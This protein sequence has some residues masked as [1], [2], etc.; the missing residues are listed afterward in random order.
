[1]SNDDDEWLCQHAGHLV[2]QSDGR[3]HV[4]WTSAARAARLYLQA[5]GGSTREAVRAARATEARACK[6]R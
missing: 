1:V 3:V 6:T 5:S 2:Y 4:E